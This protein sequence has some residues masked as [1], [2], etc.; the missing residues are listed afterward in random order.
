MALTDFRS[1]NTNVAGLTL[2]PNATAWVLG[3]WVELTPATSGDL[4]IQ[5][6][7]FS[8]NNIPALDTTVEYLFEI[9]TGAGGAESTKIQIPY[10]VRNDT[11]IGYYSNY[12][13]F[14][15]EPFFVPSGTRI[16]LRAASSLTSAGN[17]LGFKIFYIGDETLGGGSDPMGMMGF[18]GL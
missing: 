2:A 12:K 5:S 11:Q 14:I 1:L 17:Q 6:L 3:A 18:F 8:T 13:I 15:P 16:A 4:Y 9:G 10:S 7:S